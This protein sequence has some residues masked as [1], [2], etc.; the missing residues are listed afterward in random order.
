LNG[1]RAIVT[2]VVLVV[3]GGVVALLAS[4]GPGGVEVVPPQDSDVSPALFESAE[5]C[6]MCHRVIYEEWRETQHAKAYTGELVRRYTE[7][8]KKTECL[9]CH[10]PQPVH[11]AGVGNRTLARTTRLADGI[12]CLACHRRNIGGV[13]HVAAPHEDATGP[14]RPVYTPE[15]ATVD[16]C[17]GC[18]NQHWTVD[19]WNESVYARK[20]PPVTCLDCHMPKTTGPVVRGGKDRVRRRHLWPGGH[21]LDQLRKAV[22][23]GAKREGDEILVSTT[24]SG[25]GHKIPADARHRSFNVMVWFYDAS[26]NL[27]AGPEEMAEYRLYYRQ[28]PTR[29]TTQIAPKETATAR[30]ALPKDL[31]S[32]KAVV[33]LYYC[34]EPGAAI[35]LRTEGRSEE[36]TMVREIEVPLP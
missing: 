32:G 26:G 5:G 27:V 14:C 19:E 34:L 28:D 18:H 33:R 21:S 13:W 25:A 15:H 24:N 9:P 8:W 2:V 17:A 16:Q 10:V 4:G 29:T 1:T 22:T 12:D 31:A 6:G 7:N 11:E 20:T 36:A 30:R 23:F 35:I 3:A